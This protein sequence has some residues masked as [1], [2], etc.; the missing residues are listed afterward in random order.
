MRTLFD[1]LDQLDRASI[2][3][4]RADHSVCERHSEALMCL[5]P[6][7]LGEGKAWPLYYD[8]AVTSHPAQVEILA[9]Q[10]FL[11]VAVETLDVKY[12]DGGTYTMSNSQ[13]AT[14]KKSDFWYGIENYNY[15]A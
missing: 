14:I 7:F 13:Y 3:A 9:M 4:Q 2:T 5:S 15:F 1:T 6:S 8:S 12:G 10:A 11:P